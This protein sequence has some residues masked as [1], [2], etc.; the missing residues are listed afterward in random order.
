MTRTN[1]HSMKCF[2]CRCF[3][4][5]LEQLWISCPLEA[6]E[7]IC[8][9]NSQEWQDIENTGM[10]NMMIGVLHKPALLLHTQEYGLP[11]LQKQ[12]WWRPLSREDV[13]QTLVLDLSSYLDKLSKK[14]NFTGFGQ[15]RTG[16][17]LVCC[18][19]KGP[20]S[21]Y[22]RKYKWTLSSLSM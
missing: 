14:L 8:W 22:M 7:K 18:F 16:I 5:P 21:M 11:C 20:L 15:S 1:Q 19:R 6:G 17:G 3:Q 4:Q 13:T 10:K 2:K 12:K 9:I